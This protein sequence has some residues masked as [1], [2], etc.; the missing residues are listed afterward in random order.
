M[1]ATSSSAIVTK[2]LIELNRLANDETPMILGVTVVEDIFIAVYLAIVSVV[3]SGQT[4][5]W[6]VV[7][8]LAVSFAFLVVMFTVARKGGAF[9]SRFMRTRD[10]ELFTVLFFGLAILFG[11][12]GEVL[13]VTD[14]IGAFLIGLVL[15]AT[16]VRNRIE[17]I[18][19][20]LR[21]VFGAFFFL[22]FGLALDPGEFPTVVVPV[23]LAVLM[24]VVLNIIAGQF[25]AWL[26]G[27][28]AQAGINT[29]FI[30][31]NRGEFALI[32]ATLSLS[33]GLDERIQPFAGLY[34][35]VMAIMGPLLAANSV[36][37]GTAVL[38][39]K[40]RS[41]TKRAAEKAGRD[42]ERAG[43]LALF[44]AAERGEQVPADAFDDGL[45]VAGP[46]PGAVARGV[47]PGTGPRPMA[48]APCGPGR[49]MRVTPAAPRARVP[50]RPSRRA[51]RPAVRPRHLDTTHRER[52]PDY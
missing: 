44:E 30:L 8:Q 13:G 1:T 10:V 45:A 23:L 51:G 12:I 4:E 50:P 49:T 6:A 16:R 52:E 31:Q 39:T 37:I 48:R 33:A 47:T 35:L 41:A 26:N 5:P 32:L 7:G 36:R 15:G 27:H 42:A 29:A 18:A 2:L 28:G 43:A 11:G 3:L 24:T 20:P 22:N 38:P 17:Q 25:V 19:I 9:L 34:V 40:Y 21:D 46:R 14:A